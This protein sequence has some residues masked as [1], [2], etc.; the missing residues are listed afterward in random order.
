MNPQMTSMK[1]CIYLTLVNPKRFK[2]CNNSVFVLL[3]FT[4][5]RRLN[6]NKILSIAA[7][8]KAWN[9]FSVQGKLPL[10]RHGHSVSVIGSKMYVFGGQHAGSYLNDL[11]AFDIKTR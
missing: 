5:Y 3:K 6:I 11:V 9:K 1:A 8:S 4:I 2:L 7:V 10:P